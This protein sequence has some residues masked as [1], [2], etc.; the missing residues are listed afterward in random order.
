MLACADACRAHGRVEMLT[1]AVERRGQPQ[2]VGLVGCCGWMGAFSGSSDP[3]A[4]L[5]V[6]G[7]EAHARAA[8]HHACWLVDV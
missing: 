8:V 6:D 1:I 4:V 5:G 2:S 7:R 3:C